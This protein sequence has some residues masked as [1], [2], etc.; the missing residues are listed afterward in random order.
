MADYSGF[1]QGGTLDV[2]RPSAS[3]AGILEAAAGPDR[4]YQGLDDDQLTGGLGRWAAVEAWAC[5]HKLAALTE[6]VRRRGIPELGTVA[7][8]AGI[9]ADVPAGGRRAWLRRR[10]WR[11]ACPGRPPTS[12]CPWRSALA[13]RLTATC[14]A[15][16][17]GEVDFVKARVLAEVT[18][19][20]GNAAAWH[21][22]KLAL[23][24]AGGSFAGRTPGELR[25]LIEAASIAAD[26]RAAEKRRTEKERDARVASWREPEGTMAIQ[27]GG[28]NPA[29]AM[30]AE[31]AIQHRAQACK[32]AGM[33]GGMDQLRARAFTGK[34]TGKNPL[35]GDPPGTGQ[36]APGRVHL[37]APEWILPLLPC[38]DWQTTRGA[39][40]PKPAMPGRCGSGSPAGRPGPSPSTP[41]HWAPAITPPQPAARPR[42][43]APASHRNP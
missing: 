8:P 2:A 37:T 5:S 41:S 38:W 9:A 28:L 29:D 43:P 25:K 10:R 15:L 40:G 13:T 22:E 34:L 27:A 4:R 32:K 24:R 21:A 42:R 18:G 30:D 19:P 33:E 17:T 26:P 3:L 6:L 7:G 36:A 11:W 12:W 39:T 14:A 16:Q 31:A 1:S 23:A 20:L 35:G